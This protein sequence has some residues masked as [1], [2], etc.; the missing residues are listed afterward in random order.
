ML[1]RLLRWARIT[2]A[3]SDTEQFATQQVS[4]LGK[5]A[6]AL[7]VF[8]Y[9]VH[10][11]VPPDS[12]A[13]MFSVQDSADNRAAIA[14][15][16]KDRPT[17]KDTEVTFYHPPSGSLLKWDADGNLLIDNG[18]A[19]VKL[20][21]DT[22]TLNGNLVVNGTMTNNGKNVGDTHQHSQGQDSAGNTEQNINGV[23]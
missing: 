1:S 22:M 3:G 12:L 20:E 8:P 11:N 2:K 17:L 9:G 4:Y 18:Q 23:I 21:G 10:A 14:W 5:T 7:M 6:N 15:E 19:T 16:P 13:L